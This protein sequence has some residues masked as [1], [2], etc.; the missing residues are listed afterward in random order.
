MSKG[1]STEEQDALFFL[2][3]LP[4]LL[5]LQVQLNVLLH[6]LCLVAAALTCRL[7]VLF[8]NNFLAAD[9]CGS[10][11]VQDALPRSKERKPF[12]SSRR[13]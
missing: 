3:L 8:G 6:C 7:H 9:H 12:F 2:V 4:V 10:H 13:Q 11:M 5:L 1:P